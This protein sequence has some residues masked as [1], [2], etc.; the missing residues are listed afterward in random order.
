MFRHCGIELEGVPLVSVPLCDETCMHAPTRRC[1]VLPFGV[2]NG[3]S[4]FHPT[5]HLYPLGS[6]GLLNLA[7]LVLPLPRHSYDGA[8]C[9]LWSRWRLRET[10]LYLHMY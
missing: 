5:R 9:F 6:I 1:T 3:P 10:R 7:N 8:A 2:T 4:Y